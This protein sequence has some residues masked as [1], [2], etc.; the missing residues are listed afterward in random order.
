[1]QLAAALEATA[2]S[3]MVSTDSSLAASMNPQVFTTMTSA[4][5]GSSTGAKPDS[6]ETPSITSVSTRFLAHPREMKWMV[7]GAGMASLVAPT[8]PLG[9][10]STPSRLDRRHRPRRCWRPPM[11]IASPGITV[12][13]M[14]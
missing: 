12:E 10:W 1:L 9:Q 5:S 11:S 14:R 13:A 3:R 6:P 2:I 8:G 7:F 4:A